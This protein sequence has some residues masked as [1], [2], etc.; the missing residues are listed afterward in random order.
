[1]ADARRAALTDQTDI[2]GARALI[3]VRL[4]SAP[5]GVVE[6]VAAVVQDR[7]RHDARTSEAVGDGLDRHA[8]QA[9]E[10]RQVVPSKPELVGESRIPGEHHDASASDAADGRQ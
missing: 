7:H 4:G 6:A 3:E 9:L 10:G 2:S 8:R 5:E 1:M